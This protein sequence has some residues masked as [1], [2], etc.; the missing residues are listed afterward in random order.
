MFTLS[1]KLKILLTNDDGI[2]ATGINVLHNKLFDVA[3]VY[4]LAPDSNR[5]AVSSHIVMND[6]VKIK[7]HSDNI[8]SSSGYPAD[9]VIT[10][11]KSDLFNNIKFDAVLS[12]INEGPNLGTDC[13]YSGTVAAARQA[14]LYKIPGIALSLSPYN[15]C[16]D[17]NAFAEFVA[18]NLEML[19]SLYKPGVVL[20]LNAVSRNSYKGVQLTTLCIRDYKDKVHI[21][22]APD[23]NMYGFFRGGNIESFGPEKNEYEVVSNNEIAVTRFYAELVNYNEKVDN[24]NFKL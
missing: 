10:A 2:F 18:N 5:S 15:N 19:I 20:S 3:D 22:N 4:V 12:G 7:K 8:Y 14:V 9:C 23:N 6:S 16:Y 24:L 21:L 13:I 17:Y 11:I 1:N